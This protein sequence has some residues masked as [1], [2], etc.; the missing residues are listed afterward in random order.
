[1]IQHAVPK[2]FL[3]ALTFFFSLVSAKTYLDGIA[4][5]VGDEIILTSEVEAYMLMQ[6]NSMKMTPDT[7]DIPDLRKRFLD[8]LID[9]KVMLVHAKNDTNLTIRSQDVERELNN[10]IETLLLQNKISMDDLERELK[11]QG[12]TITKYKSQLR[13]GLREQLLKQQL[14][15]MH[16]MSY[17]PS[18]KDVEEFYTQYKDSL[19]TMGESYRLLKLSIDISPPDSIT[20]Q[21]WDKI[22]LIRTKLDNGADFAEMAKQYSQGPNAENGGNLGFIA[23][24]SLSELTFEEMV[25]SLEPGEISEP[26]ESRLG[27]HIVKVLSKKDQKVEVSQI[28]ISVEPPQSLL[29]QRVQILD[30]LRNSIKTKEDF[31]ASL[32]KIS[33]DDMLK[34][35]NGDIGWFTKY[36][37]T[38]Q[39]DSD[40]DTLEA[41][42]ISKP[43]KGEKA[44]SLIMIADY[45]ED[46]KLT[47]EDDWDIIEEK[48]RD[49]YGQ[50]KLIELVKKWREETLI[51]IRL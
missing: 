9:G 17:V 3:L 39:Y 47:L 13:K 15:Q 27:F 28:F 2:I 40:F 16:T 34:A 26:F 48:T 45:K 21:A 19:P 46:R 43:I 5:V 11:T 6:L 33:T 4:A 7:S 32:K 49:I 20:Q 41:G 22:T 35:R 29:D 50:K 12:L 23:K 24:G 42:Q 38:S 36:S 31:V 44:Y 14:Q 37:V 30:S 10:Y 8:E 18:K 1:M 25:F 51:D